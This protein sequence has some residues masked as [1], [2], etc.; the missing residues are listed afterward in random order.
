MNIKFRPYQI[1]ATKKIRELW[2]KGMRRILLVAPPGAGKGTLVGWYG[3][4]AAKKG[5]RTLFVVHKR[6]LVVQTA[7]RTIEQFKFDNVGFYLSGYRRRECPFMFGSIQTISRRKIADNFKLFLIDECHRVKT[8]QYQDFYERIPDDAFVIGF[9]ATPFRTDKKGFRDEFDAI[10]QLSTYNQLVKDKFLVPT[11][12]IAPKIT[13]DLSGIKTKAT[14]SGEQDFVDKELFDRY[15]QERVYR[16]VVEKWKQYAEGKKTIVFNVNSMEHSKKTAEWFRKYGID[17]RYIDSNDSVEE[18]NRKF[19]AFQCGEYPVLCNIGLFTEGISV[20][21]VDCIVFNVATQ[22]LT[23][24]VQAS[25]R[26]SRPVWD[27][28]YFDWKKGLDGNYLKEKCLILDFGG[29]VDRHGFVDDYDLVPFDLSGTPPKVGEARTRICPGKDGIECGYVVYVQTRTCPCCGYEF[30]IKQK[31]DKVYADEVEWAKVDRVERL[32]RQISESPYDKIQDMVGNKNGAH[33]MRIVGKVKGYRPTW[34]CYQAYRS[35]FTNLDPGNRANI[36]RI[37][38]QL[39]EVEVLKGM[40]GV[41]DAIDEKII[42][43]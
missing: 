5:N 39:Q 1:E 13:P 19:N 42:E 14:F 3:S 33:L 37:L 2:A 12:V 26:G 9:T 34:A 36:P 6:E 30:P 20:D 17:A 24:W 43:I 8:K 7:Q 32:C 23:K 11:E 29:N 41:Y 16:G 22:S 21:D 35:G 10:V 4:E 25:A 40:D 27:E 38:A 28:S 15:N 18:R 31:D